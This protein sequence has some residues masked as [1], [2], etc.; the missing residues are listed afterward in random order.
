MITKLAMVPMLALMSCSANAA[1]MN[2][3]LVQRLEA[4]IGA[5]QVEA[6][7]KSPYAD[8]LE[9][10][11]KREVLYTDKE[12]KFLV[13]G[14]II[15]TS[16]G[17]DL[18]EERNNELNK[19]DFKTLPLDLAVK[20]Q[21][22]NGKR[23][24]A[25][26]EDPNCGYCKKFRKTI[27]SMDNVTVYTFLFN[28]L[29]P[30]SR[31]KSHDIWCSA[32]RSKAWDEWMLNGKEPLKAASTCADIHDQVFEIGKRYRINGTPAIIFTDGTRL[33]GAVDVKVMDERLAK[34]AG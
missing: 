31:T 8:L 11:T 32:D 7:T 29:T 24:F 21:K 10:R 12:G 23:V 6:I 18:T 28:V 26:F 25:V 19:I 30:E 9:V 13:A 1:E 16:S 4:R 3:V 20:Y 15:E 2:A 34:V 17:R 14:R 33:P 22:G 5:G 27:Q